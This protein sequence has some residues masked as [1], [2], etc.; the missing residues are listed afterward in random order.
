M[1]IGE[2][3]SDFS[4]IPY[5]IRLRKEDIGTIAIIVGDPGRVPLVASYLDKPKQIGSNREFLTYCG[6]A[7]ANK[8][9]VISTG[10]GGPAAAIVVEELARL[11]IK[12]I[13]RVGTCGSLAGE[14][15]IGYLVVAEASVRLD[16][17]TRQY[18]IEGYPAAATPELTIEL[19]KAAKSLKKKYVGG[20]VASTDA[21][22]AGEE[23]AAFGGYGSP[24]S[25]NLKNDMKMANVIAFEMETSTLFVLGRL[26]G[27][28]T[29]AVLCVVDVISGSEANKFAPKAGIEDAIRTA[30]VAIK[31]YAKARQ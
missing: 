2:N 21:F 9:I 28:A 29:G 24:P 11:G 1:K 26:Y 20:L 27:I 30:I 7:G 3:T 22:Y 19:K 23:H 13:I 17:T 6:Y 10:I 16:G 5:H 18:V 31:T 15:G 4:K 12:T 8:V 25:K 14:V